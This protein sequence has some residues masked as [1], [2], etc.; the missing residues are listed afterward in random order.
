MTTDLLREVGEALYGSRWQSDLARALGVTDRTVRRWA[1]G[2]WQPAP[3]AW[4]AII[5]LL[6]ARG[7]AMAMLR[8]KLLAA[9][10]TNSGR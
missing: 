3:A 1:A 6:K 2:E 7:K 8:R 5:D 9:R 10:P 4:D